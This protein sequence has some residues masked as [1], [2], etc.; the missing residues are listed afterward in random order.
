MNAKILSSIIFLIFTN[1]IRAT[2]TIDEE[3]EKF[4]EE[5]HSVIRKSLSEV[6][7]TFQGLDYDIQDGTY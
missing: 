3:H 2:T 1:S 6:S 4:S 7:S 5:Y